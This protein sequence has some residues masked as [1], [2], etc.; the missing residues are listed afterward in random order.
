M[1]L[2]LTTPI[3]TTAVIK[4]PRYVSLVYNIAGADK[5]KSQIRKLINVPSSF[6]KQKNKSPECLL[7]QLESQRNVDLSK[8]IVNSRKYEVK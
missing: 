1:E 3:N 7:D 2:T 6:I 4:I 8:R 5:N